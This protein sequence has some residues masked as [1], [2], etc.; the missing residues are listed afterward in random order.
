MQIQIFIKKK[1]FL[2]IVMLVIFL[3]ILHIPVDIIPVHAEGFHAKDRRDRNP[4]QIILKFYT[5]EF[6]L[7]VVGFNALF[8][9]ILFAAAK[10]DAD[11]D[12]K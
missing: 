6:N 8:P 1:L 7:S 12:W 11:V 2:N 10:F 9:H 5:K 3:L 4:Y